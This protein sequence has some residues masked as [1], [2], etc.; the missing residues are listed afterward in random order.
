MTHLS[1]VL[2]TLPGLRRLNASHN[3]LRSL[4]DVGGDVSKSWSQSN[5]RHVNVSH[6]KLKGLPLCFK[7]LHYLVSL[8]VSHNQ[9]RELPSNW[10]TSVL[11]S[12]RELLACMDN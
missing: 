6:N 3:H 9:L 7:Q 11:V 12:G 5:L 10:G 4:P 1:S 2:F 8:D